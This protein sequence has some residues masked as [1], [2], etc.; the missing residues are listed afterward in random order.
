MAQRKFIITNKG[1]LR[2][3]MVELHRDLLR[4]GDMCYG[5]GYY[6]F[7][8]VSNRLILS[9]ESTDFGIPRWDWLDELHVP[10]VERG[11]RIVY[12]PTTR[13]WEDDYDV[14][15]ELKVIYDQ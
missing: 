4:P 12:V 3:G 14:S 11:L 10:E 5:G 15:A 13:S 2:M 8:Y 1:M 7:D 9:G 6:E